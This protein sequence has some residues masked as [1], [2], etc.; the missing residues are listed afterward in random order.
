VC[1]A[2]EHNNAKGNLRV[3]NAFAHVQARSKLLSIQVFAICSFGRKFPHVGLLT[4]VK[5]NAALTE[6][7]PHIMQHADKK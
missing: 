1:Y 7:N 3:A 6:A 5:L 2:T 4:P